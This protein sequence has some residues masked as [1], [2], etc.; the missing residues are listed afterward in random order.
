VELKIIRGT[1]RSTDEPAPSGARPLEYHPGTHQAAEAAPQGGDQRL[2]LLLEASNDGIWEWNLAAADG[3][4]SGR[5]YEMLGLSPDDVQ[6]ELP[7]IGV[8]VHPEDSPRFQR[9]LERLRQGESDNPVELRLRKADGDFGVFSLRGKTFSEASGLPLRAVGSL[10]DVT[11]QRLAENALRQSEQRHRALVSVLTSIVWITDPHGDFVE[12]QVSW[13]AYTGQAWEEHAGRGWLAAIHPDDRQELGRQW[14][15]AVERKQIFQA[16]GRLWHAAAGR[17]RYFAAR[18]VPMFARDGSVR[19]WVGVMRDTDDQWRA[20]FARRAAEEALRTSEVRFRTMADATPVMIRLLDDEQKCT[21]VN[22]GWL[23]FTGRT[24]E[25]EISRGWSGGIHPDDLD[26]CVEVYRGAFERREPFTLEYRLRR[27]D[28]DYRWLL[29]N[30][31]PLRSE[32]GAFQGYI[33]SCIDITHR[34]RSENRLREAADYLV[35]QRQWLESVLNLLPMP[36]LLIDPASAKVTFSNQAARQTAPAFEHRRSD[37]TGAGQLCDACG[38]PLSEAEA[39]VARVSRGERLRG[40]EVRLQHAD[41]AR[42]LVLHSESL[43][44]MHSHEQMAVLLYQDITDQKQVEA[45]LRRANQAKDA[46]LAMLGHEL[47]NPLAAITSAAELLELLDAADPEFGK[48][49][50]ILQT[51]IQHLV[52]LVDDM[53]DISRLTGGKIRIRREALDVR[54]VV[55]QSIQTCESV[56]DERRHHLSVEMP[57]EPIPVE[58]D[59]AR[60]EQVFVNLLTN[61]A[62]YTEQGGQIAVVAELNETEAVVR[63]RDNGIGIRADLLPQVFE[64]FRQLNPSLHRAEGGLGIGLNI[65]KNLVELHGGTVSATSE[66]PHRGSEFVVRLPRMTQP[67]H[68]SRHGSPTAPVAAARH[69]PLR[70]MVVEDNADIAHSMVALVR[71]LGH[72]VEL[73]H[74]GTAALELAQRFSPHVALFD[75]G[76]PGMNG[77][78]LAQAFRQDDQLRSAFLVALT[79]FGQSEDRRRSLEAGFDEHLVKPL[80]FARLQQL[81]NRFTLR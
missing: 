18:G 32:R 39:P 33:G 11:A 8:R 28:G 31:V 12:P 40:F 70:V 44:A 2:N 47:R 56:I 4:W 3:Y 53:L 15:L 42:S 57:E 36:M 9:F 26:R 30:S 77:L 14:S 66:G 79:G 17:Y 19:E 41:G 52:Q 29:D 69:A 71:H 61:A 22:R 43:P 21:Y 34:K 59:A 68:S 38:L 67:S 72:E 76:L 80:S 55:K 6:P 37:D 16:D 23:E 62:K 5:I 49:R 20:E 13:Q 63:V 24:L 58:G 46:L 74:D 73:A 50:Q 45:D 75:I 65:V 78:E 7:A 64:L 1:Q 35:E 48:S 51:H 25:Q 60:L 10:T 81:L 54:E 27:S